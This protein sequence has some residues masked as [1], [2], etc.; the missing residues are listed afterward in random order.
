MSD[1]SAM[2]PAESAGT[3]RLEMTFHSWGM[4]KKQKSQKLDEG[5]PRASDLAMSA[6]TARKRFPHRFCRPSAIF[7]GA[8]DVPDWYDS[9]RSAMVL[10]K[11]L[12]LKWLIVH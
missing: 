1:A 7:L 11:Y 3:A 12:I 5:V 9:E 4:S 6:R 8:I 2:W 10:S